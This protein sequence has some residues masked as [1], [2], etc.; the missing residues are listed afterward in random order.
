MER[1]DT[2]RSDFRTG[3]R[4]D[5]RPDSRGDTVTGWWSCTECG[6]DAELPGVDAGGVQVGC[7][8]C[9][10]VMAQSWAW[11]TARAA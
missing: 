5:L 9:D 4:T 6:V 2:G 10:G 11:D 8:D 7:P 3:A 1:S